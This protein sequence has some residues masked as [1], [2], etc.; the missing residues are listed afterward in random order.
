MLVFAAALPLFGAPPGGP[1]LAAL[2]VAAMAAIATG[3]RAGSARASVLDWPAAGF[4][5]VS[6]ATLVPFAYQPPTYHPA[7]L[8]RLAAFVPDVPPWLPLYSWRAFADLLIGFALF[9]TVRRV[10]GRS[11]GGLGIALGAGLSL[12]LVVGLAEQVGLVTLDGYRAI[13]GE[14]YGTR[15]HSVFFHSGWLA[16]YLVVATPFAVAAFLVEGATARGFGVG[17]LVLALVTIPL[18]EQRGAWFTAIVQ[19]GVFVVFEGPR[20]KRNAALRRRLVFLMLA[21]VACASV[22]VAVAPSVAVPVFDRLDS[23][24]SDL[25]GRTKLWS[26]AARLFEMRPGLGWGVGAFATAYDAMHPRG[27]SGA[28]A[29]RD[30]AH[31]LYF[32]VAA[33]RGSLGL[34]ALVVLGS[35]LLYCVWNVARRG[36]PRERALALGLLLSGTGLAIIGLVQDTF[37]IRNIHWLSWLLAGAAASFCPSRGANGVRFAARMLSILALVLVP[38]RAFMLQPPSSA[39]NHSFGFHEAEGS[40]A[41]SM[42]WTT[43]YAV[44]RVPWT[45]SVLVV[46][47]ANGHPKA[48]EHPVE[49]T[50]RIDGRELSRTTLRGG[51]EELRFELGSPRRAWLLFELEARP[52]FRPFVDFRRLPGVP[53]SIDFRSLGVAVGEI[54][55]E[56]PLPSA[57]ASQATNSFKVHEPVRRRAL[58]ETA[59]LGR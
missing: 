28:W 18:T 52:T 53:A 35:A 58:I 5:V 11:L 16:E 51:W 8:V 2:D 45:G 21:A 55:W 57:G 26:S 15:L 3:W 17:L 59:S 56:G 22:I 32:N 46:P 14:L 38:W 19:C 9:H 43:A 1:Y 27:S 12:V 13:G 36:E 50:V 48:S 23:A 47:L 37:Y 34:A 6:A 31:S 39:D 40:G 25:S 49:V 54:R 41:T 7:I 42:R 10:F 29:Y 44:R 20:L 30:T 33:E 4:V 24:F